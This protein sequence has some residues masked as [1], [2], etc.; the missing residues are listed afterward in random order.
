MQAVLFDPIGR[1][2]TGGA[3]P[4]EPKALLVEC[5]FVFSLVLGP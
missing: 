4:A 1:A 5:D 2:A 3:F